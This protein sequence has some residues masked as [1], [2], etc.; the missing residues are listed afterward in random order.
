MQSSII[1]IYPEDLMD[2]LS[3]YLVGYWRFNECALHSDRALFVFLLRSFI[4]KNTK[5]YEL[6]QNK[7]VIPV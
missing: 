7:A 1:T 2:N 6:M 3:I 5:A 4:I